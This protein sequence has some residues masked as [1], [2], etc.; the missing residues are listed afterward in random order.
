M[1]NKKSQCKHKSPPPQ[2][3]G[4]MS[5][6]HESR[7]ARNTHTFLPLYSKISTHGHISLPI[8]KDPPALDARATRRASTVDRR[9][10]GRR[11]SRRRHRGISSNRISTIAGTD[12]SSERT[13]PNRTERAPSS[14][15][16]RSSASA[17]LDKKRGDGGASTPHRIVFLIRYANHRRDVRNL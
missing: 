2:K 17:P 1:I 11:A 14:K 5:A 6:F 7:T 9:R 13:E 4:S 15:R 16:I 3:L 8:R 10:A 12:S